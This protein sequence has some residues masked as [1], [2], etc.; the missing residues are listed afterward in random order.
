MTPVASVAGRESSRRR[1][2]VEPAEPAGEELGRL[3]EV[4]RAALTGYCYRMLGSP[5][6]AEDAVQETFLRAWRAYENFEARGAFRSWL[7]AIAT[8]VCMTILSGRRRRAL[9]MDLASPSSGTALPGDALADS[10]WIEPMPDGRLLPPDS[11]PAELVAARDTIRLAFIAALQYLP[12][13]QRAVLILRDVLRWRAA[14]VAELLEVS[15]KAANGLLRRA[16]ATL[17]GL[18]LTTAPVKVNQ[19]RD[20]ALLARY[21]DAFERLDIDALVSLLREDAVFS[22]PP[23][24]LWLQG[25]SAVRDWLL[26]R[27]CADSVV[28]RVAANGSP[29]FAVYKPA[30][31]GLDLEAYGVQVLELSPSGISEIHTFLNSDLFSLFD[32]PV[33]VRRHAALRD[34]T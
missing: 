28:V 22:M 25:R 13:R 31:N 19:P 1:R 3:L 2:I 18:N 17:G 29:A 7:Y 21:V 20:E 30:G 11:D 16:R 12:P 15:V 27:D 34:W 5:H 8:N 4:E 6:E 33:I 14:E 10:V 32:L 9:P 23:F 24:A 26:R